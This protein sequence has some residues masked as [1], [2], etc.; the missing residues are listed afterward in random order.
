MEDLRA[1]RAVSHDLTNSFLRD[2]GVD[3]PLRP[4]AESARILAAIARQADFTLFEFILTDM[5]GHS[6]DMNAAQ[7]VVQRLDIL[8]QEVLSRLDLNETTVL[9]TSDHGNFEDLST[10]RHSMNLVPTCVWGS[11]QEYFN[12]IELRI[13]DLAGMMRGSLA[14]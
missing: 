12:S 5:I 10:K 7:E 2:M 6:R 1:G 14:S 11:G 3:V 13:E 8:L 4:P 9:L